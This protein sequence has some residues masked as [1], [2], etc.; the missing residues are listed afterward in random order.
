[1][2]SRF[3]ILETKLDNLNVLQPKRL[4]DH[5]GYLERMFCAEDLNTFL[6]SRTIIQIN[7]T[8]TEKKGTVRGM[9]F[10]LPPYSEMKFVSCLKGKV[11]DVAVDLRTHSAT[12]LKWHA[13]ILSADNHKI[14]VIPEGFAHGFQ[15]LSNDCEMLYFHT[16]AYYPPAENGLNPRDPALAIDWP[17]TISEI[18][19]RDSNH[20]FISTP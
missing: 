5:R 18:S 20:P 4:G 19:Q 1:M 11:F 3:D 12:Y 16:A 6:E 8:Y 7:R 10:Q 9:H 17:L 2:S 14:L 15:A 13:E